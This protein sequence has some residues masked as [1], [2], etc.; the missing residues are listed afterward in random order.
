MQIN[1][2]EASCELNEIDGLDEIS[3][4]RCKFL[5]HLYVAPEHRKQGH[6]KALLKQ[7]NKEADEAGITLLLHPQ[8]EF[9]DAMTTEQLIK[10]YAKHGYIQFQKEP[11]LMI[12]WNSW[13]YKQPSPAHR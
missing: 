10:F 4:Q 13:A 8:A 11:L 5:S 9:D 1:I 3:A 6:A 12:R 7:I 2:G